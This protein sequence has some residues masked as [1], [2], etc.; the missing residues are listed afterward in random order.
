MRQLCKFTFVAS[1]LTAR[2]RRASRSQRVLANSFAFALILTG[3]ASTARAGIT[4]LDVDPS[5]VSNAEG[6]GTSTVT[7]Y[8]GVAGQC[9][10]NQQSS[11]T[12]TCSSCLQT[13]GGDTNLQPCN[14]RRINPN[15]VL[16][17]G[18]KSDSV[19]QGYPE[20][21]A[22]PATT[23][24]T[25]TGQFITQTG[26]SSPVGKGSE[27]TISVTWGNICQHLLTVD[28]VSGGSTGAPVPNCDFTSIPA[29]GA[30]A[31]FYVGMTTN[32][33]ESGFSG[34]AST[35]TGSTT[36][37]TTTTASDDYAQITI[38]IRRGDSNAGTTGSLDVTNNTG[39]VYFEMHSGDNKG[40]ITNTQSGTGSSGFPNF[41]SVKFENLRILFEQRS[42][43]N[44]PVWGNINPGSPH[45][46]LAITADATNSQNYSFSPTY[47]SSGHATKSDGTGY[48]VSISNGA[49][50]DI[51]VA[52]VDSAGNVGFYTGSANDKNCDDTVGA[53]SAGSG[54]L[55][56][57]TIRPNVV[58][59][60]LA[61]KVNC[62][63]A[64]A[65]FG[66]PMAKEVDTF[67]HFR[68]TY[69]IPNK[70]GLKF[71]RWYYDHGAAYA[72]FIA[73]SDTYRAIARGLLWLPLQFAKVSL[74]YGLFAGL[75]FLFLSFAL[76]VALLAWGY[77]RLVR[78][79]GRVDV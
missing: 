31:T 32:P 77:R 13:A 24:G 26:N 72:K 66:S 28:P 37:T 48:D 76:P 73:Q 54:V 11:Q 12:S 5:R 67:R 60:V 55:E 40:Y 8:G 22:A 15:L 10:T 14:D 58:V 74:N 23:T 18:I 69:L 7:I 21:E 49:V 43:P 53:L 38:A 62:F 64:T 3:A 42:D 39:I 25:T 68:D 30:Q 20:I 52:V 46:D 4:V 6:L 79:Q 71:V 63:I 41:E 56:C 16:T 59:G 9:A 47:L 57:H 17:I 2:L 19:D 51:K 45:Q 27:G 70:F 65:A 78:R 61:N 44:T 1:V 33:T 36:G 34:T 35:T 75:A 50:Y 29:D